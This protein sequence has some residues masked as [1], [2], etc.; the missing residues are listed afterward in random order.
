M[1][2]R[3]L[4]DAVALRPSN[5]AVSTAAT[6]FVDRQGPTAELVLPEPDH[7]RTYLTCAHPLD[8]TYAWWG[9]P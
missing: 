7:V 8:L 3:K 4:L 6:A 9:Y 2:S 1:P 5:V